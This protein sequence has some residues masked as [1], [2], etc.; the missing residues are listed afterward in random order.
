LWARW[1]AH[2]SAMFD[3]SPCLACAVI[4]QARADGELT[5][6]VES[7]SMAKLLTHWALR[8]NLGV[9]VA[10]APTCFTPSTYQP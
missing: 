5:P 2:P 3:A 1:Q 4:G 7:R 6:A 9:A 10:R 8:A